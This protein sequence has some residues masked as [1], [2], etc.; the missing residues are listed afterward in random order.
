MQLSTGTHTCCPK[1]VR[2]GLVCA[3]SGGEVQEKWRRVPCMLSH[4]P[5]SLQAPLHCCPPP[6]TRRAKGWP[7]DSDAPPRAGLQGPVP[8]G[9]SLGSAGHCMC[10]VKGH[11]APSPA[12]LGSPGASASVTV[13]AIRLH[14]TG[15]YEERTTSGFCCAF[16]LRIQ[17]QLVPSGRWAA[18]WPGPWT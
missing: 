5:C 4:G 11:P 3:C 15:V 10:S 9:S 14:N 6:V 7:C 12:A 13:S 2:W 1:R 17:K 8:L 18:M 16:W